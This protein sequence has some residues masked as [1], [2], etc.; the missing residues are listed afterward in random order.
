MNM[1]RVWPI[2]CEFGVGALLC[3]VGIWCGLR[4]GYLN[5]KVAEDRRLLVVL[6]AGYLLMLA[7]VCVFT[8]LAPNWANGE[9]L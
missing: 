1:L 8:F 6:V 7:I 9:S 4:G 2:V 5:L 3:L